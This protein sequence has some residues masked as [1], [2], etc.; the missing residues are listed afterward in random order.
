MPFNLIGG[1]FERHCDREANGFSLGRRSGG[2]K[3]VADK[4]REGRDDRKDQNVGCGRPLEQEGQTA[5]DNETLHLRFPLGRAER[6]GEA[7][8]GG[9]AMEDCV[10]IIAGGQAKGKEGQGRSKKSQQDG[11][12]LYSS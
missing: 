1:S 9:E 6:Q 10:T 4:G 3:G 12:R 7:L 11:G 2:G 5:Q 8:Y